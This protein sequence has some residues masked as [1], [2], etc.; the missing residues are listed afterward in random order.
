MIREAKTENGIV[1]GLP[2]GNNRIT[3][4]KGIPF[5]APPVGENRWRAPKPAL[6]WEGVRLC[7][8]FAPISVQDTPGLGTD[9]YCREWHVDPDIAM[10][11]DCLYLNI[12]TPAKSPDDNLPVLI[13][14]FGGAFQ[15]GY[16]NEMEFDG[17]H[18]AKQGIIVVSINY[19]LGALGFLS[20]EEL[21]KNQPDGYANFGHLDQQAGLKWV[22]RN[23]K[24]FGGDPNRITI[25][26]QSAG[27]ASTLTQLT[28][29][30]NYNDISGAVILSG[31]IRDPF[32][33]D[34]LIRPISLS[35]AEKRGAEFIKYLGV[36]SIDEARK[37]DAFFIR[38][39]YAKFRETH[40]IMFSTIIDESFIKED[41][42]E[43]FLAGRRAN[44]PVISG[45]TGDEFFSG[46]DAKNI[47]ELQEKAT[48]FYGKDADK[49]LSFTEANKQ[50]D[51]AFSLLSIIEVSTKAAFY[52]N[53]KNTNMAPCYYYRFI[54][55][56]PGFD[57]PGTF[58]SVDLWFWFNNLD[59][60]WRPMVGRHYDL[61]RT[62]SGYLVNLVKTGNPNGQDS[63]EY[64]LPKWNAF[65]DLSKF[66]MNFTKDGASGT[67]DTNEFIDF[68]AK[69]IGHLI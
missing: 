16:P 15:W 40:G 4:Y 23:I 31:M 18:L 66:E 17:E 38:D 8:D 42:F 51:G 53:A 33:I 3:T 43:A 32:H 19:R 62:M 13:W 11:E 60:C 35:D 27:G 45:N 46:I 21:T 52:C 22:K 10:S 39:K 5:A 67:N 6:N 9:I 64:E 29:P 26:G 58:H 56:I 12:W 49:F 2:A 59:K 54:P 20:H 1:R 69:K 63:N 14:Y 41:P 61:A 44:V 28:R 48:I 68:V 36:S 57:N 34:N 55:D 7:Y 47:E 37:L 50:T 24:A 25:S 30:E 65:D